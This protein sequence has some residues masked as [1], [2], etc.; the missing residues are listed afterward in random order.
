MARFRRFRRRYRPMRRRRFYRR[1]RGGGSRHI[2]HKSKIFGF[3][4]L[5]VAAVAAF[6][7]I[8][9]FKSLVLGLIGKKED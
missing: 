9:Q 2:T 5:L 4:I 8:P 3:P 1:R 6:F 7:F